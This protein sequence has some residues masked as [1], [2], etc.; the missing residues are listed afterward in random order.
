M[1]GEVSKHF[2]VIR[3]DSAGTGSGG[4][5]LNTTPGLAGGVQY[6]PRSCRGARRARH[7][8]P[9][10][11]GGRTSGAAKSADNVLNALFDVP[12]YIEKCIETF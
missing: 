11:A 12:K 6:C 8:A 5:L 10:L 3:A 1:L 2:F 7:S 9:K 4:D